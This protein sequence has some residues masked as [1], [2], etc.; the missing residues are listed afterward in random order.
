MKYAAALVF[1]LALG[2]CT[3]AQDDHARAQAHQDADQIRHDAREA[4]HDAKIETK[5][6]TSELD[7]DLHKA[8][9]KTRQAL[10]EP[11]D[12][13]DKPRQ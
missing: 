13:T 7:A 4:L 9:E 12:R 3:P 1:A 6:A 8:R 11:A 10:D 2:A 5:K